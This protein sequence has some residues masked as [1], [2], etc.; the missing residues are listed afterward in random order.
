MH[1]TLPEAS[2]GFQILHY[3]SGVLAVLALLVL[4]PQV[5]T[6]KAPHPTLVVFPLALTALVI[7]A[8]TR[9]LLLDN[10]VTL[11]LDIAEAIIASTVIVEEYYAIVAA[12]GGPVHALTSFQQADI[13]ITMS[14]PLCCFSLCWPKLNRGTF[15]FLR[16]AMLQIVVIKPAV[17]LTTFI[18]YLKEGTESGTPP[19]LTLLN[20]LCMPLAMYGASVLLQSV[21]PESQADNPRINA[22]TSRLFLVQLYAIP[23]VMSM[24]HTKAHVFPNTQEFSDYSAMITLYSCIQLF[25]FLVLAVQ[26]LRS[27]RAYRAHVGGDVE[28]HKAHY[29]VLPNDEE[30]RV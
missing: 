2:L 9:T 21:S 13:G 4:S 16:F 15:R 28:D 18:L 1:W 3:A 6:R 27:A 10:G 7:I 19:A 11:V 20:P 8:A 22:K 5:F 25:G 12:L 17:A 14:A 23:A 24:L 26:G 30:G 29:S